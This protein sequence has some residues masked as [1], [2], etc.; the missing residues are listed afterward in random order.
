MKIYVREQK[1]TD[2]LFSSSTASGVV[3]TTNW[4]AETLV[5]DVSRMSR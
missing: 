2:E 4:S 3:M 1:E 5:H